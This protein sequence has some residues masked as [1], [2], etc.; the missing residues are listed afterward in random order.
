MENL[1]TTLGSQGE[2]AH[3]HTSHPLKTT[4]RKYYCDQMANAEMLHN[5]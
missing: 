2:P 4:A 3:H 1:L 5:V